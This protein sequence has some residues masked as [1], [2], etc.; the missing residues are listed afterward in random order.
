MRITLRRR[1]L[2]L[3]LRSK[4]VEGNEPHEIP[5]KK[6]K[7]VQAFLKKINYVQNFAVEVNYV[8]NYVVEVN[9]VQILWE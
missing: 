3:Q 8:Q 7:Y 6:I 5:G 4:C 1:F 2:N 9:Y